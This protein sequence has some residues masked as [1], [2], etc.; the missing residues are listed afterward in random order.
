MLEEEAEAELADA[1]LG[2][3]S[4]EEAELVVELLEEEAEAELADVL[5]GDLSEE[6]AKEIVLDIEWELLLEDED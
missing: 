1:L 2:D 4:E 3:L 5:L 6:E